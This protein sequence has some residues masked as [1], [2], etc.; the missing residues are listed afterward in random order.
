[1]AYGFYF[2]ISSMANGRHF[3]FLWTGRRPYHCIFQRKQ[4][5]QATTPDTHFVVQSTISRMVSKPR[6]YAIHL[7]WVL[8]QQGMERGRALRRAHVFGQTVGAD[9]SVSFR[10]KGVVQNIALQ[11]RIWQ[12]VPALLVRGI[13]D[14]AAVAEYYVNRRGQMAGPLEGWPV[15]V[16]TR[17]FCHATLQ[18]ATVRFVGNGSHHQ[19]HVQGLLLPDKVKGMVQAV[20]DYLQEINDD[21]EAATDGKLQVTYTAAKATTQGGVVVRPLDDVVIGQPQLWALMEDDEKVATMSPDAVAQITW[22][23]DEPDGFSYKVAPGVV[24]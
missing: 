20:V 13:D 14:C 8:P 24:A 23:P 6:H 2:V 12:Q 1:M 22:D 11:R 17:P 21:D 16:A 18:Q 10:A 3:L 7:I 19:V 5:E 4:H 9:V 15:W